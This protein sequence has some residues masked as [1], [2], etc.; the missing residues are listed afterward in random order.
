MTSHNQFEGVTAAPS[1]GIFSQLRD[2]VAQQPSDR[3]IALVTSGG[4]TVPLESRTVRFID[5]FSVGTRG[6]A[7]AEWFLR[8]G[9]AVVFLHRRGSLEPFSRH[10]PRSGL[11]E[12]LEFSPTSSAPCLQ[13]K[14]DVS[15]Q[16]APVLREYK[17][18]IRD[19]RLLKIEFNTVQ[20]YLGLLLT[21]AEIL[22]PL[23]KKLLVY[24]SAAVSDFYIP[25]CDLPEHKPAEQQRPF[26]FASAACSQGAA[27]FG[28]VLLT[29]CFHSKLQVGNGCHSVDA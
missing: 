12:L 2:F 26:G 23:S 19:T 4:T 28:T 14:S 22:A 7:S 20:E 6:A 17:D 21:A 11:L 9:Y 8:H 1:P 18:C 15:S 25:L 27:T 10:L 24:L 29:K 13:L 16:L 3:L 5:N